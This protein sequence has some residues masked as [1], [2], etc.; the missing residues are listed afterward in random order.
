MYL[1]EIEEVL[2]L[3]GTLSAIANP[4][5][6]TGRLDVFTRII[7]DQSDAFDVVPPAYAGKLWAEVSPRTFDVMVRRG[8]RLAQLRFR[9]RTSSQHIYSTFRLS[10]TELEALHDKG[11]LTDEDSHHSTRSKP[12]GEPQERQRFQYNRLSSEAVH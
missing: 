7:A 6:S 3:G 10:D 12:Q 5:S 8:T 9:R 4:K 11:R 2:R 1:I